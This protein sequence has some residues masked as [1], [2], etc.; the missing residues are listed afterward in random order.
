MQV[1][2]AFA[3][4]KMAE[5][6]AVCLHAVVLADTAGGSE[7]SSVDIAAAIGCA[8]VVCS[9]ASGMCWILHVCTPIE[10]GLAR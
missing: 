8:C 3:G 1:K 6:R 10:R 2:L 4:G 5:V 7:E 9:T